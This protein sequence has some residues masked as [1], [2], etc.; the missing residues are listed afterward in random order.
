MPLFQFFTS[1][2]SSQL[3]A[4]FALKVAQVLSESLN[5]PL[6][7]FAIHVIPDQQIYIA[8]DPSNT[9]NTAYAILRSIGVVTADD[10]RRHTT[11]LSQFVEKELGIP[12]EQFRL[13][14]LDLDPNKTAIKSKICTDLGL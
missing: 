12:N 3:P 14:F 5:K 1:K 13:F 7:R 2:S 11:K 10:N 8:G 4:N 6:D 9:N